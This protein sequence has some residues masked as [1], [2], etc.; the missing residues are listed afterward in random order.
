MSTESA[1]TTPGTD[2]IPPLQR[3]I[4][5]LRARLD[6]IQD[7][8]ALA[9]VDRLRRIVERMRASGEADAE[10]AEF[11]LPSIR[12]MLKRLGTAF[13][14]RNKAEQVHIVRVN[15]RRERV[16]TRE[17]PRPESIAEAV[18]ILHAAGF[19]L[20]ATLGTIDR[21][22]IQPTLTAHPTESRRRTIIQKQ[23]RI[24]E[25]LRVV[26]A[27]D[28][29]ETECA[30]AAAGVR[31]ALAVTLGTDEIR[32]S[33]PEVVDEVR[34]G[35]H[36]LAGVIREAVPVVH[37][38]LLDAIERHYGTRPSGLP[39]FLR[40]RSWIGGDR[41]GNPN[42]TAAVTESTLEAMR[43]AAIEGHLGNLEILHRDLSLSDRR[44]PI[45]AELLATIDRDAG[46]FGETD[47][48]AAY[49]RHEPFRRRIRQIE[50]RLRPET[51][52]A[53]GG[54]AARDLLADLEIL[55]RALHEAGLAEVADGGALADAIVQ[56]RTFG[57]HLAGLDLRQHSRVHEAAVA[58]L[59]RLGGVEDDYASLDEAGKVAMLRAELETSRPLLARDAT[60]SPETRELLDTLAVVKRTIDREPDAIGSYIVS[61]AHAASDL[62]EVLVL[63]REAGLWSRDETGVACPIDVAP[64]FETVD[65]LA[66]AKTVLE[67]MFSDPM[68]REHLESRGR[69]QE[70][71]LGYSDSNKDGGYWAAN[72]RLQVAQDELARTCEDAGVEFRF[73]HGRGG[74]VARGGGR[75]HRAILSSPVA[76][77]NGRIRF[78][79]QGEVISFRYAMPALANR[80]LEQIANA[81]LLASSG[82]AGT[83]DEASIDAVDAADD[84]MDELAEASRKTYRELIDAP[85]FWP[86]FEG[87]SP[88]RF[89]GEL[90]IASRPVSRTG[91]GLHFENLRAI[92]WVFAWTQM[93]CNVPGWYGIGTAFERVVLGDPSNLEACRTAYRAGGHFRAFIDNAQQEMARARLMV[94][95]WYLGREDPLHR[96]IV[97]EFDRAERAVLGITG[98]V[99]LLDNNPVIRESIRE[100]NPETDLINALQVELLRRVREGAFEDETEMKNVVLLGVNALA[101]AMQS[102]G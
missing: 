33:R 2:R 73:F 30:R 46:R 36:H 40:Y 85:D 86:V 96:R 71:M 95:G 66:H 45:A 26:D 12:A 67:G 21:L 56:V 27:P 3:D 23:A 63:F 72:W 42:V 53:A 50:C 49:L 20:E 25:L 75:A 16:A 29:G 99:G 54:Y 87:R 15:R 89:I 7:G 37:R 28:A 11:E 82:C 81:M 68:Y 78:T 1:S 102:T 19:D 93:R 22:D 34:T 48:D 94:G 8:T 88:V 35:V 24:A 38:D 61:M 76:S 44:V 77:R 55:H 84:L 69:F 98:Q 39:T 64:L 80:H 13:H 32:S 6:E 52:E 101:A 41:D 51:T 65:D 90:P 58:D 10:L 5:W 9:D 92:P 100:R 70:I 18:G 91:G 97:A 43:A 59:L 31:R 62:Y 14:L 60:M 47:A 57:F 17:T 79:E 4:S 83:A 74:T